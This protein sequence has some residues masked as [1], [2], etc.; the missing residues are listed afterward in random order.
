[1]NVKKL[2]MG[3]VC[4]IMLSFQPALATIITSETENISGN[5]WESRYTITNDTVDEIFWFAILFEASEYENIAYVPSIEFG[6]DWDI[7]VVQPFI[8]DAGYV[9]AFSF[10]AGIGA[11]SFMSNFI[12]RYEYLGSIA[13]GL[14]D[15]EIYDPNSID[16]LVIESGDFQTSIVS[17]PTAVSAPS[18]LLLFGMSV[19]VLCR[20]RKAKTATLTP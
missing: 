4:F 20:P 16:P 7:F 8:T 15:F 12:V 9:D 3:L 6:P 11:G 14:Q 1:M 17:A 10:G 13:P 19:L 18:T 2:T 5:I